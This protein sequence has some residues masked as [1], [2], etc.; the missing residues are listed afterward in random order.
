M[1]QYVHN[2]AKNHIIFLKNNKIFVQNNNIVRANIKLN[3]ILS[4][5]QNYA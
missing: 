2:N 3:M 4:N 5:Q 1:N